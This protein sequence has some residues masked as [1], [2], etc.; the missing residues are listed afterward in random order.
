MAGSAAVLEIDIDAYGTHGRTTCLADYLEY[1]AVIGGP[2]RLSH[3][4]DLVRDR[5]WGRRDLDLVSPSSAFEEWENDVSPAIPKFESDES[6]VVDRVGRIL[7]YRHTY[8]GSAY[9]FELAGDG[10]S[11]SLSLKKACDRDKRDE[12]VYISLLSV[13]LAHAYSLTVSGLQAASI[14]DAFESYVAFV[15]SQCGLRAV[16]VPTFG[17]SLEKKIPIVVGPL[18]LR[19][20]VA[21]ASFSKKA[22][23]GGTDI[24]CHVPHSDPRLLPCFVLLGQAT[25]GQTET[26]QAKATQPSIAAWR[27]MLLMEYDPVSFLAV[28]HHIDPRHWPL[29]AQESATPIVDR[30][31]LVAMSKIPTSD[32]VAV[33]KRVFGSSYDWAL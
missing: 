12:V 13:T 3:L 2:C 5:E 11:A 1:K 22:K 31:R 14:E 24:V 6:E 16:V 25:C 26:W 10:M 9:P 23:D 19:P 21:H 17:E 7:Q 33:A 8:L 28:P 18:G 20:N 30:I 29:L 15:F 32:G 27:K 4:A